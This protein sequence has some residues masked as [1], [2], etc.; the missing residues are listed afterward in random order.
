M[1]ILFIVHRVPCPPNKG[2]KLRAVWMLRELSKRHS[3]DLF[4][5]Y[6]DRED[7]SHVHELSQ[8]CR[9]Y[10]LE[11]ISF[12]KSRVRALA[13]LLLKR[14]F[15]TEFFR[16]GRM[17]M[18]VESA[19][20]SGYYDRIVVF[21]SSMAQYARDTGNIT[22]VLDMVDVDSD[23]WL[24]YA[25]QSSWPWSWLWRREGRLLGEYEASIVADFCNTIVCTD[26]EAQLLRSRA[27]IGRITVLQ[28]LLDVDQYCPKQ[29]PL[30][31]FVRAWQPYV[32]FS[33]SMDYRPNIDAVKYFCAEVLPLIREQLPKLQFIIAGRN[34]SSSILALKTDPNIEVTGAV[35]DMRPYLWGAAVA[36]APMR[37]ARGVQSKILEALASGIPVV[38]TTAAASALPPSL[39]DLLLAADRPEDMSAAVLK[40]L[41]NG[42]E[43]PSH[44]LRASLRTCI[45]KL[46]LEAQLERLILD[47]KNDLEKTEGINRRGLSLLSLGVVPRREHLES[48]TS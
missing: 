25:N 26:A 35:P 47:P 4:S 21:S 15:T 33:G 43:F 24:Q 42:S 2:E 29:Q 22:K 12:L 36:V 14:P 17:A 30:P 31:D 48:K 18:R 16:S 19:L 23:K 27:S 34:P 5:F 13:A 1:R 45:K 38:A 9:T 44:H 7:L 8:Y 32:L 3:V 40:L 41:R 20:C 37:I 39:R 6:D 46:D 11:K 28:N 10:Y